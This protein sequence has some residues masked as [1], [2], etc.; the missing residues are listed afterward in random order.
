MTYFFSYD[1]SDNRKRRRA[2][3]ILDRFGVRVQKSFFQCDV[4]PA[5]AERIKELLL[6]RFN[7][8]E[9][10]LICCPVCAECTGKIRLLGKGELMQNPTFQIL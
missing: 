6:L 8:K 2:A 7:P 1:I 10:S 4:D 5:M 9:D 3:A